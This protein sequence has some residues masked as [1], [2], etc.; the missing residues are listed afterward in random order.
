MASTLPLLLLL[1]LATVGTAARVTA[2]VTPQQDSEAAEV[3][4]KVGPLK[5][6]H[7][8]SA[9]LKMQYDRPSRA[10]VAW[11]PCQT[12]PPVNLS[13]AWQ[14]CHSDAEASA[15]VTWFKQHLDYVTTASPILHTLGEN[16]SLVEIPFAPGSVSTPA[17]LFHDLRAA[18]VRVLPTLWNDESDESRYNHTLLP[19]LRALF[20]DPAPLIGR[21]VQLAMAY[22]LDGWSL[23][24]ELGASEVVTAHDGDGLVH[25]VDEL[26][27]QLEQ[28]G[29]S[30]SLEMG[31]W[32]AHDR[33][34]PYAT[35][36]DGCP[37]GPTTCLLWNRTA[38]A[39]SRL[40]SAVDM[41]TYADSRGDPADFTQFVIS[42]GR[43]LESFSCG[44]IAIGLCPECTN[45]SRPLTAA[46]LSARF[47]VIEGLG[48]CV[49]SL[50]LWFGT[51]TDHVSQVWG[52]YLP[53]LRQY[54][55]GGRRRVLPAKHDDV[56][57]PRQLQLPRATAQP[58][59]AA[60][61]RPPPPLPSW[62]GP[63]P[64]ANTRWAQS[65]ARLSFC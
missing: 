50:W 3:A 40:H 20:A 9:T 30:L 19:K 65:A 17:S 1:L 16:G 21:L 5:A 6:V 32:G 12:T 43:M 44:K 23:D 24:F 54:I 62:V 14:G 56:P 38:L 51:D 49:Q 42:T 34:V 35:W 63:A 58:P 39:T 15:G 4:A 26:A 60:G 28:R 61:A 27:A 59:P 29:K 37:W 55:S 64:G 8:D 53:L 46:Q 45:H 52:G 22:D 7:V 13:T 48:D 11:W 18:G 41:S 57:P 10:V 33:F 2:T 47:G 36:P 31:T 25:F